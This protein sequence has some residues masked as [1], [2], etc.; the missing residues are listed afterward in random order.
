MKRNLAPSVVLA[1]G[2]LLGM[3]GS[4]QASDFWD[5]VAAQ[6]SSTVIGTGV[7]QYDVNT[8]LNRANVQAAWVESGAVNG[9]QAGVFDA[10]DQLSGTLDIYDRNGVLLLQSPANLTRAGVDAW[11]AANA[12][13][14]FNALFP[15]GISELT[16]A[17][18]DNILV[19]ATVSQNL[20]KKATPAKKDQ[21]ANAV[22]AKN[23]VGEASA[24]YQRL[25]VNDYHG[26]ATSLVLG[27]SKEAESGFSYSVTIPYRATQINDDL[28]SKSRFLGL[29][30]AGKYPVKKWANN[31]WNLGGCLFGSAFELKTDTLDKAGNLKYGGGLFT[32]FNRDFGFG[33]FGVGLD[34][35]IAKAYMPESMNSDSLFFEQTADYVNHHE[36]VQT[37]SYGFNIGLPLAGDAAA[38]N[39]EVVRSNFISDDIPS[40]QKGK[41]SVGLAG[42]FYPS[43]TFELNLG[44]SRD[45]GIDKVKGYGFLLG[46]INRF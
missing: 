19:S 30:M 11:A 15:A 25:K 32:S 6:V 44:I 29:E 34:Y 2:I 26:R 7:Y 8:N 13:A 46:V 10:L 12:A 16:G 20:F 22:A 24:E 38:V 37:F 33:K 18:D 31:E 23:E 45:F 4:A 40:A 21:G 43:D 27:F 3:G 36:P 5:L 35:R 28:G 41:T 14:I 9:G 42:S 17:T 1:A 39:L